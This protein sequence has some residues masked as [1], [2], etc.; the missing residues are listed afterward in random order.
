MHD[1]CAFFRKSEG[2]NP[3]A[4]FLLKRTTLTRKERRWKQKQASLQTT[5]DALARSKI[6]LDPKRLKPEQETP[7][8]GCGCGM[9]IERPLTH[10]ARS[11]K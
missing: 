5:I 8:E 6:G 10:E 4:N 11:M 3:A 9:W 7:F 2:S 1:S